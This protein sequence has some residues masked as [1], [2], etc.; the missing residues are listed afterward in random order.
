[1]HTKLMILQAEKERMQTELATAIAG[2]DRN[3]DIVRWMSERVRDI[4]IEIAEQ[5]RKGGTA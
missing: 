1:M 5:I 2:I 4:D 3:A